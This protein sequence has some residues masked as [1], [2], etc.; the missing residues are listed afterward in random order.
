MDEPDI[1]PDNP[2]FFFISGTGIWLDTGLDM[3]D[4]RP[5][6]AYTY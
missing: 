5:Y 1:P 4:I 3:P 2:A 6:K